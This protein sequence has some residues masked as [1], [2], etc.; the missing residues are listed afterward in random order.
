MELTYD[1][2]YN[3]A[4]LRFR[5]KTEEVETIRVTDDL[6]VDIAPDGTV[7]GIEFLNANE[8]L[9]TKEIGKFLV[10]DE[11]TGEQVEVPLWKEE[12]IM[13]NRVWRLVTH[14][15]PRKKKPA[16]DKYW[17]E[18]FIALGW[19][20][21]DL[22]DI[23]PSCPEDIGE[24][25]TAHPECHNNNIPGGRACLWALYKPELRSGDLV[26]LSLYYDRDFERV[27]QVRDDNYHFVLEDDPVIG[28]Y[29]HRRFVDQRP[30]VLVRQLWE[31]SG[32]PA[33]GWYPMWP[34]VLCK[35]PYTGPR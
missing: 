3:T 21:E 14:H 32:G 1:P 35:N 15:E 11:A 4:Y 17:E 33:V 26:I 24:Y 9:R 6:N 20:T 25:L 18:G 8:Q 13:S 7:F 10:T 31:R 12:G 34:L 5:E 27:V 30:D 28:H 16:L 29:R 23:N 2:R 19:P 22:R